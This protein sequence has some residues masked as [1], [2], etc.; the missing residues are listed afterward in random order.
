MTVGLKYCI[1]CLYPETKPDL[2]FNENGLCSACQNF[3]GRKNIDFPERAEQFLKIVIR[4]SAKSPY[5]V[6]VPVSGGKD[7][8]YQVV[9][10]KELG[11]RV[12][13]VNA[14]TDLLSDIGRVN[15]D[16]IGRL[17]D[18]V[19][20]TPHQ[21][22][23]KAIMKFALRE[24]GDWSWCEHVLIHTV[25]FREAIQRG[26][27]TIVFGELA[28]HE[29]G[30]GPKGSEDQQRMTRRWVEEFGGLLGLRVEDIKDI[31]G[32]TSK[33]VAMYTF[34]TQ[35]ELELSGV[36]AVW[37]GN[38]FQWD[39]Y[40][41][42]EISR[43]HGFKT[44]WG[45]HIEGSYANYENLDNLFTG[46]R[47]Y[48]RYVKYGYGRC[49]D[50]VSNHIRRGRMEREEGLMFVR[51]RDGDIP[52][53]YLGTPLGV[54]TDYIGISVMDFID[55]ARKFANK[56]LFDTSAPGWPKPLFEAH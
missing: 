17:C 41:N 29:Y 31:L 44:W 18:L 37:L 5:D 10:C 6:I 28:Q 43:K 54:M 7:S 50:I 21:E 51:E 4:G 36:Q 56:R 3:D 42:S 30:A 13:A 52:T 12:L 25:P 39:G 48:L 53:S 49:T 47:D 15:I 9:K 22:H 55:V 34:P 35:E 24:V 1:R 27:K 32:L 8:T 2:R 11:L 16:N 26:V 20:V 40:E 19:E 38:Y 23:R 46:P 45:T 14:K 33:D